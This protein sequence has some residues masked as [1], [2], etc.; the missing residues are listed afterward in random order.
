MEEERCHRA[1]FLVTGHSGIG[2]LDWLPPKA[3]TNPTL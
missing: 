3:L 1:I 2:L